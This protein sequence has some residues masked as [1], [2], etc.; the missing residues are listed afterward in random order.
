MCIEFNL[1]LCICVRS[2]YRPADDGK[3]RPSNEGKYSG[4]NGKY[5]H[6]DSKYVH[7]DGGKGGSGKNGAGADDVVQINFRNANAGTI[8]RTT[9]TTK[10]AAAAAVNKPPTPTVTIFE[11][12]SPR[13]SQDGKP[14]GGWAILRQELTEDETGYRYL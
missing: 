14:N 13:V 10:P 12:I 5:D 2:R 3:Y 11:K 8:T 1:I 6:K 9:T 4:D 7:K